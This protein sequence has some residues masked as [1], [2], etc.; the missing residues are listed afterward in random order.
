VRLHGLIFKKVILCCE[1][2]FFPKKNFTK[3]LEYYYQKTSKSGKAY[4]NGPVNLVKAVTDHYSHGYSL[5]GNDIPDIIQS[6]I[7]AKK[8]PEDTNA[9]Y[10]VLTAGD[11]NETM[12]DDLGGASF[13]SEYCGYHVSWQLTSGKRIFYSQVG[14]PTACMSGCAPVENESVS[15][16]GDLG[17]DAMTSVIAHE[18]VEAISDPESDGNRAWEDSYGYEN[19][20]KCAWSYGSTKKDRSGFLYNVEF[21]GKKY[22]IQQNWSVRLQNCA[23][24]A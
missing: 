24:S 17:I 6:H 9:V 12:R 22:L 8:L 11:V 4:T 3:I 1:R 16:N 18:L 21:A 7:D 13:C 2:V 10:F 5:S 14:N 20:D 19:A 23:S 15:P